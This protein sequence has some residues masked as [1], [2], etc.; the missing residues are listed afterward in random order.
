MEQK[1]IDKLKEQH[2]GCKVVEFDDGK[3]AVFAK[4]S[5]TVVGLLMLN[6][7][8]RGPLSAADTLINNCWLGGDEEVKTDVGYAVGLVGVLDELTASKKAEVKN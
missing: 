7:R 2:P 4:P 5:R 3:I 8:E 1:Q 6:L